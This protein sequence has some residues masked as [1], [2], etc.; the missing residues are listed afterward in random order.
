MPLVHIYCGTGGLFLLF[1]CGAK[2]FQRADFIFEIA[3]D[4]IVGEYL[5]RIQ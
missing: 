1:F 3:A 2:S 4:H 5:A